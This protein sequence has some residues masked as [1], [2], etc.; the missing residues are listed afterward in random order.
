MKFAIVSQAKDPAVTYALL[1]GIGSSLV[2]QAAKDFAS[3]WET[4][5]CEVDVFLTAAAVPED[6]CLML[7]VDDIPEAPSALAYHSLTASGRPMLRLGWETIKQN[8]GTLIKGPNSMSSAMSHEVL[9]TI[10]DPYVGFWSDFNDG[11]NEIALEVCLSGDTE[12]A[13]PSGPVTIAKLAGSGMPAEIFGVTSN[14]KSRSAIATNIRMTKKLANICVVTLADGRTIRCTKE[15]RIMLS[16]GSYCVAG[17]LDIGSKLFDVRP[18]SSRSNATDCRRT[19]TE[20]FGESDAE[21]FIRSDNYDITFGKFGASMT[22]PLKVSVPP[23][24]TFDRRVNHIFSMSPKKKVFGIRA[25]SVVTNMADFISVRDRSNEMFV[26]QAVNGEMFASESHLT[27]SG[28]GDRS[29]PAPTSFST[30]HASKECIRSRSQ[31]SS[32]S[33]SKPRIK[34][35]MS[36]ISGS[37]Q[38]AKTFGKMWTEAPFNGT[39]SH[40]AIVASVEDAGYSDVFDLSVPATKNVILANGLVVH[41]CDPVQGDSYEIDGIAVSNSNA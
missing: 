29:G 36:F 18:S 28:C 13:T 16:D 9:E 8:G 39:C 7:V 14:G 10:A 15:H 38:A 11:L 37:M 34:S 24:S 40:G 20:F 19:H 3:F 33:P 2:K 30:F 1:V 6:R 35:A 22:R 32:I 12:I 23:H 27:V 21:F 4:L 41:N 17:D 26:R 5:P 25:S 31:R